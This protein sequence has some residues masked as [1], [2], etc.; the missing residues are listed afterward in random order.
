MRRGCLALALAL[1]GCSRFAILHDALSANEHNDLG[2]AYE[3]SGDRQAAAREYRRAL[4]GDPRLSRARVNL[5]N[6]EAAAGRWKSAEH[7][8]RLA[9]AVA[10]GD[11]D[12]RNNLAVALLRRRR[13]LD[14]AEWLARSAVALAGRRDTIARATLSEVRAAARRR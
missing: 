4:R 13:S 14:E 11:A 3:S 7:Q 2:V 10:P 5:G 1:L 12:A 6:V 9:L 8:Y